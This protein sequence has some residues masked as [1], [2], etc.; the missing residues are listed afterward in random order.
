MGESPIGRCMTLGAD[1]D[2]PSGRVTVHGLRSRS[3]EPWSSRFVIWLPYLFYRTTL[4][5]ATVSGG[6][7]PIPAPEN[8]RKE[9]SFQQQTKPE[10]RSQRCQLREARY[11]DNRSLLN[12]N[13]DGQVPVHR[14]PSH[15]SAPGDGRGG[16]G[17]SR[18]LGMAA[19]IADRVVAMCGEQVVDQAGLE[20]LFRSPRHAHMRG[21]LG[22]G[23]APPRGARRVNDRR[24]SRA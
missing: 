2:R 8:C 7:R 16:V 5:Q 20:E 19:Y 6:F 17:L 4:L 22:R 9:I 13:S 24:G 1:L 10:T 14:S 15:A 12:L 21:L 23:P 3:F 11:T 18:D